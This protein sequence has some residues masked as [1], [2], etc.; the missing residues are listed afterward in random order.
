LR[1]TKRKCACIAKSILTVR[2]KASVP[3]EASLQNL[4]KEGNN[5][6]REYRNVE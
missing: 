5:E 4:E 1:K 2:I 6:N 3:L